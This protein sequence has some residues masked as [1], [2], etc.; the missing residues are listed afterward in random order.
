MNFH[1]KDSLQ[2]LFVLINYASQVP[3]S[4]Q[5]QQYH[6]CPIS[7]RNKLSESVR[8]TGW[9]SSSCRPAAC[10]SCSPAGGRGTRSCAACGR[11][12]LTRAPAFWL[13]GMGAWSAGGTGWP[14][15]RSQAP[16]RAGPAALRRPGSGQAAGSAAQP[17]LRAGA[18]NSL[19]VRCAR[20]ASMARESSREESAGFSA[21]AAP[22]L[23]CPHRRPAS[24]GLSRARLVFAAARPAPA[25][26]KPG[27]ATLTSASPWE[28]EVRLRVIPNQRRP[29]GE[30]AWRYL[31]WAIGRPAAPVSPPGLWS[32]HLP[33]LRAFRQPLLLCRFLGP[34]MCSSQSHSPHLHG[35]HVDIG[36]PHDDLPFYKK[37][38]CFLLP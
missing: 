30:A 20:L 21:P 9:G 13:D 35:P 1:G 11:F 8:S 25:A 36:A 2:L 28:P 6:S 33:L 37:R 18:P 4:T 3:L 38:T 19:R 7:G 5:C 34:T 29:C 16:C 23:C 10:W 27:A 32:A 14:G 17:A 15:R 22:S 24:A 31:A 12:D 26:R